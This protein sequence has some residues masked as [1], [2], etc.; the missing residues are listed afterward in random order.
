LD[1]FVVLQKL[2]EVDKLKA[3]LLNSDQI[4]LFENLPKPV[5]ERESRKLLK[6]KYDLT[7]AQIAAGG[8]YV[9]QTKVEKI[10]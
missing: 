9:G 10:S 2:R 4:T 3:I 7:H 8:T 5:L 6:Q 1:I